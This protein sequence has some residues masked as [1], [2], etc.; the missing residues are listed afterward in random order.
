MRELFK[1]VPA[2]IIEPKLFYSKNKIQI[3]LI[4][5]GGTWYINKLR[6]KPYTVKRPILSKKYR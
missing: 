6:A 2:A 1:K 5:I 4:Y 3:F